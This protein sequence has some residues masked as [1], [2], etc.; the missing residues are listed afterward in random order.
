V[1]RGV[2]ELHASYFGS[3][4]KPLLGIYSP[5][6]GRAQRDAVVL[7]CHP[8][9]Q[10]YMRSYWALRRL[11]ARLADE[12]FHVFRFDYYATGDSAGDSVAASLAEWRENVV[13]ALDEARDVSGARRACVVGLGL[14]ATL[15]AQAKLRV[16]DL[17]LW[18]PVVSGSAHLAELRSAHERQLAHNLQTPR[19]PRRGPVLELLGHPLPATLQ[20]ELESL[21][22]RRPFACTC[23][24]VLLV[25]AEHRP[26]Y[27]RLI[28][29]GAAPPLRLET[30]PREQTRDEPFLMWP[31]AER[32][33]AELLTGKLA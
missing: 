22:L 14:G 5:P 17:V 15:A 2:P 1:R 21:E 13:A 32:R 29:A 26:A 28:E 24:R 4:D 7:V 3:S 11:A 9:P 10:E 27:A 23:A 20:T 16:Q 30:T 33:I 25:A 12:G 19:L 18:E 6:S 8:A 31:A